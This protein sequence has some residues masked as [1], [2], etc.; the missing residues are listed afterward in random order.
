MLS[1]RTCLPRFKNTKQNRERK[2]KP[3]PLYLFHLFF[4]CQPPVP[5]QEEQHPLKQ[6]SPP[7]NRATEKLGSGGVGNWL[8]PFC[9][10]MKPQREP[11]DI[12][13]FQQN[14][15]HCL[16]FLCVIPLPD[17]CPLKGAPQQPQRA[18]SQL[19]VMRSTSP[20]PLPPPVMQPGT[21][22]PACRQQSVASPKGVL[23]LSCALGAV[24]SSLHSGNRAATRL[25]GKE[26]LGFQAVGVVETP[27][28]SSR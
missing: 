8:C 16:A 18:A 22:N 14:R 24:S 6:P 4:E 27:S 28:R 11:Q 25:S 3:S 10:G 2:S 26:V 23:V 20:R 17:T 9:K 13:I 5:P 15:K 12:G 1:L 19:V 21:G 7:A